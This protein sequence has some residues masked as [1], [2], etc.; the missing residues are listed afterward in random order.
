M[1]DGV[2]AG[3]FRRGRDRHA[4]AVPELVRFGA[5]ARVSTATATAAMVGTTINITNHVTVAGNLD[6]TSRH[7]RKRVAD[8]M[9]EEINAALRTWDKA[10]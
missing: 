6:L 9:V 7:A 4:P 1:R 10:H 2:R 8:A 3:P 5:R